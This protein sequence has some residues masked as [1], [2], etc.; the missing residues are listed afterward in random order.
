M[1]TPLFWDGVMRRLRAEMP[2]VALEAWVRPLAVEGDE[3]ELRLLCPTAFHRDRLRERYLPAIHRAME[4]ELGARVP[5]TVEV[6][7]DAQ[8]PDPPPASPGP[9]NLAPTG[10]RHVAHAPLAPAVAQPAPEPAQ[11]LLPYRFENFVVGPCNALAREAALALARGRGLGLNT[12]FL[13]SPPGLGKTHLARAV[14]VEARRTGTDRVIYAPAESFTNE[15]MSSIRAQ[16]MASFKRRFR[17]E[18]SLLVVEDVQFLQRKAATQLELFHTL[19]HLLGVGGRVVLTAD[20][21][22]RDIPDL[23]PRL[24]SQMSSGFVAEIEP[25]D[26]QVR[27]IILRR[28]A[29]AGGIGL[30]EECLDR[31][32]EAVHGSVRDLESVLVQLVASAALLKRPIDLALTEAALR[33]LAAPRAPLLGQLEL[34][35][36]IEVV[37]AFF[38]TTPAAL[39]TRSRRR[40]V[41]LPRQLAMYLCRRYT[42]ASLQRIGDALGRDHPAVSHAVAA[43]ER[44]I[45]ERAPLRYQVE[46]LAARLDERAQ[47]AAPAPSAARTAS[48]G[49][50]RRPPGDGETP[51]GGLWP[52][53]APSRPRREAAS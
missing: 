30:P 53:K 19:Q 44:R 47:A 31:L 5:L 42:S 33:K 15:F 41:L 24:R 28:R 35:T 40:D 2:A 20:Q 38:K 21:L 36:V 39:A 51:P 45:L 32:V 46:A 22:P 49:E 16:R 17:E 48:R 50:S 29:D 18:C 52:T 37:A 12:L 9:R 13:A 27:R 8:Q 3:K 34:D 23:D 6:R 4:A 10:R 43:V 26:A 7:T 14:L 25:P 11:P 1:K